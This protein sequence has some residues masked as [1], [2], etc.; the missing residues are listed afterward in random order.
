M[1]RLRL[2][3]LYQEVLKLNYTDLLFGEQMGLFY[4]RNKFQVFQKEE[5]IIDNKCRV[6]GIKRT[7]ILEKCLKT[8]NS[9]KTRK[10][11]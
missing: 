1:E 9:K 8:N 2:Y 10:S 3:F 11:L 6:E 7:V 4:E 5:V